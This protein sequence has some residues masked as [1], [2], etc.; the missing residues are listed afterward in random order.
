VL[1]TP[2]LR[3]LRHNMPNAWITLVVTPG[4]RSVV[5]RCPYVDEVRTYDWRR[6]RLLGPLHHLHTATV[7]TRDLIRHRYDLAIVPCWGVDYY[8]AT[9]VAYFSGAVWRVGYSERVTETKRRLNRGFDR[10]FTHCSLDG[11]LKHEVEHNLDLI[12]FVGG[13][14]ESNRLELWTGSDDDAFA[15]RI[16]AENGV[17]PDELLV[18]I[19]PGAGAPKRRW[20]LD[21][22]V[23]LTRWL[24]GRFGARIVVVGGPGEEPLGRALHDAVGNSII[25]LIGQASVLQTAAV[26]KR[27]RLFIGNDSGPMHIAAAAGARVVEV[28]CHSLHGSPLHDNSPDRFGP[29]GVGHIVLRPREALPPC[30]GDCSAPNAHC[31]ERITYEEV[32][33]A[34]AECLS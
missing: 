1:S 28:S 25:D 3:E 21:R 5:A 32:Q 20:P 2:F 16:L 27:C 7:T 34:V 6:S 11:G 19:A 14:V 31:I 24:I 33:A 10:L 23:A 29:W 8:L 13:A 18:A 9:F 22:F 4:A 12:R 26:L 17:H 30:T 15:T